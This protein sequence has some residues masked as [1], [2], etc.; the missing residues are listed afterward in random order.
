M[1]ERSLA[2]AV[3]IVLS[4]AAEPARAA[5]AKP[6]AR[7]AAVASERV[8]AR[9]AGQPI[10]V[11]ELDARQEHVERVYVERTG[12]QIPEG[13]ETF[14]RRSALDEIVHDRLVRLDALANGVT[15][16][17]AE[18][19]SLLKADDDFTRGGRFDLAA[20]A[21][22]KRE[23][24][25]GYAEAMRQ[26]KEALAGL[27]HGR[28]LEAR[29]TPSSDEIDRLWRQRYGRVRAQAVFVPALEP[30][31]GPEPSDD[32]VASAY[33]RRGAEFIW[34]AELDYSILS[35]T[36][37]GVSDADRGARAAQALADAKRGVPLDSLAARINGR[38]THHHW[39]EGQDAAG[40]RENP[41]MLE[42]ALA[43]PAGGVV[44][45]VI[46]SPEGFYFV[47]VDRSRPRGP[48]PLARVAGEVRSRLAEERLEAERRKEA[49]AAYDKNPKAWVSPA[50]QV[51]W[52]LVDSA[53][54]EARTP[55]DAELA[56]WYDQ[57]P[58]AFAR[59]DPAGGGIRVPP[60]AEVRAQ[61]IERW[62]VEQRSG[63][64][65]RLAD[66]T[67]SAWSAGQGAPGG[68]AVLAGGPAWIVEGGTRPDGLTADLADSVRSWPDAGHALVRSNPRG[69]EVVQL[70][71][72]DPNFRT[73]WPLAEPRVRAEL[74]R[75]RASAD[76]V[77][78]RTWFE[79]HRD[80][81]RTGRG[82]V[83]THVPVTVPDRSL[84]DVPASAIES[85][86]ADHAAELGEPERV[87]VRHVLIR[88][89]PGG[90][91]EAEGRA[92]RILARVRAG[93]DFATV[94]QSA[95]DDPLTRDRGGDLGWMKRGEAPGPFEAAAFA[96][97][98]QQPISGVV[99]TEFGW[100]IIRLE[101]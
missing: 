39:L 85:Y 34:P 47:R 16:S 28:E 88:P 3:A 77:L 84:V 29:L 24:P 89:G 30:S 94:A 12:R 18:A 5:V 69:F 96:L 61:A 13:Y 100:H 32:E 99:R 62:R 42:Q 50:W 60:L 58:T 54:V 83:L 46:E 68:A 98:K 11:R 6:S 80:R 56:A 86:Y 2:V 78:A 57:H 25:K 26:A 93:E 59:V 79:A 55:T 27:R 38:V 37:T 92:R 33:A 53:K 51:R 101:D 63:E 7:P 20:Y 70:M 97:T 66:A 75:R 45:R 49:K 82:Y 52:A 87:R 91:A 43:T 40:L 8:V 90:A 41:G 36:T 74:D 15:V 4:F 9:V 72:V 76:T 35:V 73:P 10:V 67:A 31:V 64:A 19:E 81:Y 22:Y 17:D 48:A 21:R 95:S 14:F 1:M 23:N 71:R 44:D 65:R